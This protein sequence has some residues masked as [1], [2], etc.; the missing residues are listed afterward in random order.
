M[1][2]QYQEENDSLR[3]TMRKMQQNGSNGEDKPE[4]RGGTAEEEG[5]S[6]SSHEAS[7]SNEY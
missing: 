1:L 6:N 5:K 3:A 4:N 7:R 2:M